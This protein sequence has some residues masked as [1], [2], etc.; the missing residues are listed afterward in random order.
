MKSKWLGNFLIILGIGFVC[1]TAGS[2]AYYAYIQHAMFKDM[3]TLVM[4]TSAIPLEPI[5]KPSTNTPTSEPGGSS[6]SPPPDHRTG[7]S[8]PEP[9]NPNQSPSQGTGSNEPGK[10]ETAGKSTLVSIG[11]MEIPKIH[12]KMIIMEGTE[13]AQLAV[14]I[15]HVTGTAFP[16]QLGN[17]SVAGHRS[18]SAAKPFE[19]LDKLENGDIIRFLAGSNDYKYEVF[20]KFVVEPTDV[21]VLKQ[22]K[23]ESIATVITCEYVSIGVKKRLIVQARLIEP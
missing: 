4:D 20:D 19:N 15:G 6:S 10:P 21:W 13:P 12:V 23:E 9:Q 3:E 11:T 2:Q 17:C 5:P 1:Y 18:G 16:G 14:G 8:P 22:N 7:E